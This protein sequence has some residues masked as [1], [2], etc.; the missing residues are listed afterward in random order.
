MVS[1]KP[2][3]SN[4]EDHQRGL[5]FVVLFPLTLSQSSIVLNGV[6]VLFLQP[7]VSSHCQN[8]R[9]LFLSSLRA[10]AFLAA[11]YCKTNLKFSLHD[12]VFKDLEMMN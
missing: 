9:M 11:R 3:R 6:N 5:S 4:T 7:N 1:R 12:D 10:L 8:G 2:L